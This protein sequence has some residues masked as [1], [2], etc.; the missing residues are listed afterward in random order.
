MNP[1]T[2]PQMTL[3]ILTRLHRTIYSNVTVVKVTL[4]L[5]K[6]AYKQNKSFYKYDIEETVGKVVYLLNV[7]MVIKMH[8]A[9]QMFRDFDDVVIFLDKIKNRFGNRSKMI[10][11]DKTSDLLKSHLCYL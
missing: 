7:I 6:N 11:C 1:G 9:Q 8:F 4:D 3:V 10:W 2:T 5:W